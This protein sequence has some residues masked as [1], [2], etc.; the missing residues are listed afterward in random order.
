CTQHPGYVTNGTDNCPSTSNPS[1]ADFDHDGLGDACDSDVDGDAVPNNVDQCPNTPLG[2]PVSIKG[3]PKAVNADQ[4]KNNGWKTL[5]RQNGTTF[6][7]QGDC[8]QYVNTGK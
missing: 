1:Q 2:T 7:N 4:C 8:I 6:K 5:Q 3:C